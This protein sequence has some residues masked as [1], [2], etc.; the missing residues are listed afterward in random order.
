MRFIF[1][2]V[3]SFSFAVLQP[4]VATADSTIT[5]KP[6]PIQKLFVRGELYYACTGTGP[7]SRFLEQ[8]QTVVDAKQNINGCGSVKMTVVTRRDDYVARDGRR[9]QIY[10]FL[11]NGWDFYTYNQVRY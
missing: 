2:L 3:V 1:C 8:S 7:L 11:V 4:A 9:F 5:L 6:S 10:R